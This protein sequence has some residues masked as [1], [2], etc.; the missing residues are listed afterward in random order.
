MGKM[1]M[2][3]SLPPLPLP[4]ALLGATV[5]GK[6]NFFTIVWFNMLQDNPPLIGAAMSKR[7]YTKNGIKEHGAFSLNIPPAHMAQVV[8]YCGLHSGAKVDKAGLFNIFYG[9]LET[10]PMIQE[11]IL[12]IACKLV[13]SKEFRTTELI[14]GEIAEMYCEERYLTEGNPDYRKM[15]PMIFFM[16]DGPYFRAGDFLAE[17]YKVGKNYM[18]SQPAPNSDRV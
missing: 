3:W 18:V 10:A 6:A 13:D 16:P 14:I 15:K 17:A 9:E 7:R 1:K 11:C 8:D 4:V 2:D 5:S 12:N